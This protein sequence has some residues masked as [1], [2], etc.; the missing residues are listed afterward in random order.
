MINIELLT[1]ED[2]VPGIYKLRVSE[3]MV[4][5]FL[6][7]TNENRPSSELAIKISHRYYGRSLYR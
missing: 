4:N 7:G 1:M 2:G 6:Y 5:P 3:Y